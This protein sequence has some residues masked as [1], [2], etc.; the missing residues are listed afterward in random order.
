MLTPLT[1]AVRR[2]RKMPF[3]SDMVKV[4]MAK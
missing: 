4:K 1:S 2:I 3:E